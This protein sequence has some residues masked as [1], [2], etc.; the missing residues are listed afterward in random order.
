M[1]NRPTIM[2]T[3]DDGIDGAG[4]Q[5]LVQVLVS[6]NLYQVFVC[7]PE[8]ERSAFSHTITW[9][10]PLQVKQ[11]E[12]KGATAF[13]VAGT[14]ADCAS[15]G[16]SKALFPVVPD[17]VISGINKGSNCGYHIVYSGTVAGARE[18]FFQGLPSISISYDWV[19]G[20][21]TVNDFKFSAEACLPIISSILVEIKSRTYPQKCFLNI[22]LPTDVL[23]HKGFKLTKQGNSIIR[24][25]WKKITSEAQV[26]KILSTMT[27]EPDTTNFDKNA[28]KVSQGSQNNLLFMR[29][30]VGVQVGEI[31]TDYY[32]LQEGYITVSPLSALTHVETDCEAY[33]KTWLPGVTERFSASAL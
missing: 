3:N 1:D 6:T 13:A 17:L 23:N 30:I 16:I 18:A 5:A 19:G 27:M 32:S 33:F 8:S 2:V 4:L 10:H 12:I 21:S 29:E 22:D 7:A 24:M 9:Q 20:K 11:V 14:P 28:T 26:G 25:G 15:L 31:D